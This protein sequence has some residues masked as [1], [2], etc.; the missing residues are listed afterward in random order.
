MKRALLFVFS[1]LMLGGLFAQQAP[2][3]PAPNAEKASLIYLDRSQV[4]DFTI[5]DTDG[6]ELNLYETLAQGKT[7][8]I[9]LFFCGCGYCQQYAPIIEQIYENT[10]AGEEDILFWGISDR[11]SD[12]AIQSYKQTHG[13]SNPC[14]GAAGGGANATNVVNQGQNFQG[15]P[16]YCVIC[17]DKEMD[18][19]PCYPP[20][21]TGFNA[22]FEQCA[23]VVALSAQFTA[24]DTDVCDTDQVLFTDG[25]A[26]APTAWEW[27]FEGGEPASSTE[28]NPSVTYAAAG[29]YDVSLT[30]TKDGETNTLDMADYITVHNCTGIENQDVQK[31]HIYPNPS[32]GRFALQADVQLR[33]TI[34]VMNLMGEVIYQDV[35][36]AGTQ[37]YEV[38]LQQAATGTYLVKV[39]DNT[40]TRIV[41]LQID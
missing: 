37:N 11:D 2:K 28:Q 7:V 1:F 35:I 10:G 31:L 16:T 34:Q 29:V 22:S 3:C 38:N 26:G 8:F 36:E 6:N 40:Q 14:A 32:Q 13:V 21:V 4:G 24:D 30:V 9:D 5:T 19:D 33:S 25:S 41:K 17:P 12:A 27:T 39:S 20:T 23:S 15:W 18:Y